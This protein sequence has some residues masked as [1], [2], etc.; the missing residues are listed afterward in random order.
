MTGK[1]GSN[2]NGLRILH[3]DDIEN[4]WRSKIIGRDFSLVFIVFILWWLLFLHNLSHNL[5]SLYVF[6]WL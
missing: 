1:K 2:W 4:L 5:K 6:G 3:A